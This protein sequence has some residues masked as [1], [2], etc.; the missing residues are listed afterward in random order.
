MVLMK[1]IVLN[2]FQVYSYDV[3]GVIDYAYKINEKKYKL[4]NETLWYNKVLDLPF[5]DKRNSSKII[6]SKHYIDDKHCYTIEKIITRY[7]PG[8]L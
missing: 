3:L 5:F 8:F 1:L 6:N 4:D 2:S 7:L